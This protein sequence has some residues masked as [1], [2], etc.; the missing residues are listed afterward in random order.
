M[1]KLGKESSL[2]LNIDGHALFN[3]IGAPAALLDK[4]FN[5]VDVNTEFTKA[6]GYKRQELKGESSLTVYDPAIFSDVR[7][8][9]VRLSHMT[10]DTL[11]GERR[12]ISPAIGP[13][14]AIVRISSVQDTDG[15]RHYLMIFEDVHQSTETERVL[16]SRSEMYKVTIEQSPV[17]ISIQDQNYRIILVNKA[18]S[19]LT[20][21]SQHELLGQD[22]ADFLHPPE[23]RDTIDYQRDKV[24]SSTIRSLPR[25]S[26]VRH[27]MHRDGRRIP[28]RLE[29]GPSRAI[30]GSPLWCAMLIDLSK[31]REAQMELRAQLDLGNRLQ[32]RFDTFATLTSDAVLVTDRESGRIIY[33]N[34]SVLDV[35]GVERQSAA[36]GSVSDLWAA[37]N[38]EQRQEAIDAIMNPSEY[39]AHELIIKVDHEQVGP[40]SV[41]LR[42]YSLGKQHGECFIIAEDI[43]DTLR[44][45]RDR[46]EEA[47]RQRDVLVREIHHRMKNN[48]HGLV[49]LVQRQANKGG[50]LEQF[51][52]D[53]VGQ[54]AAVAEVHGMQFEHLDSVSPS[55]LT[56]TVAK[57][58]SSLFDYELNFS[59]D[60]DLT[61]Q[62]W[63]IND[64]EVVP[65]ALV[66]NELMTNACKHGSVRNVLAVQVSSNQEQAV[67]KI[68]N[69]GQLPDG[70][71]FDSYR[72]GFRGLGLIHALT[73]ADGMSVSFHNEDESVVTTV[74][75]KPPA[76]NAV[77]QAA[78]Q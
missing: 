56:E 63:E 65:L 20:G 8:D 52:D 60:T 7:R 22:P 53:I 27:L 6:F 24:D 12:I 43:S 32:N 73:P 33:A 66:V 19:E 4:E 64:N 13:S 21:Y 51:V 31:Q 50:E 29:F 54:I 16:F 59:A 75:L 14:N 36:G 34:D 57:S 45:E 1:N 69:T 40:I 61:D 37:V 17:P 42:L 76:L 11:V 26:V 10:T 30:D 47:H 62:P 77:S 3:A 41:R 58:L 23:S 25:I 18:Y 72:Q 28:Y 55:F 9:R 44:R 78:D 49:G 39:G 46:I 68:T 67:I 48:L 2:P 71:D 70:F 35:L 15:T 38:S 74:R 5:F